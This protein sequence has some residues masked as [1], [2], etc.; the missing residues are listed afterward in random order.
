LASSSQAPTAAQLAAAQETTAIP[1][2]KLLSISGTNYQ[3]G[4]LFEESSAELANFNSRIAAYGSMRNTDPI[5]GGITNAV[6]SS[7]LS[8]RWGYVKPHPG[9]TDEPRDFLN[10]AFGVGDKISS[11]RMSVSWENFLQMAMLHYHEGVRYFET[12]WRIDGELGGRDT[13]KVWLDR[14]SDCEPS[15]HECWHRN[16]GQFAG[17]TQ[18]DV[19]GEG[20]PAA[21]R[22]VPANKLLLLNHRASGSN[23]EGVGALRSIHWLHK[24]KRLCVD[25]GSIA[26][27]RWA[28]GTP[29]MEID[30]E[31]LARLKAQG[32][33]EDIFGETDSVVDALK[34]ALKAYISGENNFLVSLKAFPITVFG[35][36]AFDPS[37]VLALIQHANQEMVVAYL[38]QHLLMGT[39]GGGSRALGK[40]T[41]NF[42]QASL[43]NILDRIGNAVGTSVGGTADRLLAWNFPNL[44]Q[45]ERP[46]LRHE[47]L[48]DVPMLE[49]LGMISSLIQSGALT[50]TN[51]SEAFIRQLLRQEPLATDE[52]RDVA[53]RLAGAGSVQAPAGSGPRPSRGEG[54]EQ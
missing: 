49:A 4:Q 25:M 16:N 21:E 37:A 30:H 42:L 12:V 53:E 28:V 2:D 36:D 39:Q 14:F 22:F 52:E 7:C 17:V 44:P 50:P 3:S 33:I 32:A 45:S 29:Y 13:P 43:T 27:E 5:V 38:V 51:S 47:G 48:N 20:K 54:V 40:S 18:Q 19:F 24:W 8:A 9:A 34:T 15:A 41:I 31:V 6:D 11:G 35:A 10:E 46:L 1:L 23:Y 26:T